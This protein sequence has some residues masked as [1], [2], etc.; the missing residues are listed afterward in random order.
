VSRMMGEI[1]AA[2]L[3]CGRV[4]KSLVDGLCANATR[5]NNKDDNG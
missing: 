2:M 5:D 4:P 3:A 1:P